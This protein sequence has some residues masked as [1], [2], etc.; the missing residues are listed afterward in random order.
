VYPGARPE[1]FPSTRAAARRSTPQRGPRRW[2]VCGLRVRMEASLFRIGG[3]CQM[4]M[5]ASCVSVGESHLVSL[6]GPDATRD[7]GPADPCRVVCVRRHSAD[8]AGHTAACPAV[9]IADVYIMNNLGIP[10]L[11][12][13]SLKHPPPIE[14]LQKR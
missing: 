2:F 5:H 12:I 1:E 3:S 14:R 8:T 7:P 6:A 10:T 4:C 9:K 13:R 11:I